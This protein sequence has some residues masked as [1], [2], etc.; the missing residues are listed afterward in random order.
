MRIPLVGR[1]PVR[2]CGRNVLKAFVPSATALLAVVMLASCSSGEPEAKSGQPCGVSASSEEGVLLKE[3]LGA[4]EFEALVYNSTDDVA[5]TLRSAL[6]GM[7]PAGRTSPKQTCALWAAGQNGGDRVTFSFRWVSRTS[8]EA[9]QPLPDAVPFQTAGGAHGQANDTDTAMLVT[10]EMPGELG[11]PSKAAWLQA[12]ASRP[13]GPPRTD[14]DQAARDRQTALTYLMARRVTDALGCENKP[15][16]E[17][18]VVKPAPG[19]AGQG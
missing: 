3:I 19:S 11:G 8:T 14:V 9:E 16:A 17:P 18:P 10:C 4:Q 12:K 7:S 6:P 5:T 1:L 15:L 2:T 13:A